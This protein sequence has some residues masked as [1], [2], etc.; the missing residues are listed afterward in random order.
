MARTGD[1]SSI[2]AR[3]GEHLR[4]AAED[5]V[6]L[7]AVG[8]WRDIEF[9][10]EALPELGPADV[11][12]S[13]EFLGHRLRAPLLI[14]GMTGGHDAA[15]GINAAL[16]SGAERRGVALGLGSQRAALLD[17]TL[18][19]TYSVVRSVAPTAFVLGNI[20][21]AQLLPQGAE[22]PLSNPQLRAAV[23]M[24]RADAL[25]IHLNFLEESVQVEGDRNA[26]GGLEAIARVVSAL[27][28]P[29]VAKETGAGISRPTSL[30]LAA[31]GVAALDVGG[32]G[33]TSF[34]AIEGRR[35][36]LLGQARG[37]RLGAMLRDWGI[38][39]PVSVV[40]ARKSGL[41]V[42]ATGGIRTGLDAAKA[43]ALGAT[44]A[45]VARPLLLAARDGEE[46][47]QAWIDG[48]LEELRT[49][50]FLLGARTT[51]DLR[52]ARLVIGGRTREWLEQLG[53]LDELQNYARE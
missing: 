8:P 44:L 38:P 32:R 17:P 7:A 46:G 52:R 36:E 45:G 37:S 13:V 4:L 24:V 47:V 33:G 31:A 15:R 29:V 2:E 27:D 34:A 23:A 28:V 51:G 1:A 19:P 11:D 10:H 5:D 6:D 3:K 43:I 49:V 18:A 26:A 25:A 9:E 14:A 12:L 35:A 30:R 16:A 20:G 48:F 42:I 53:L 50:M 39:T 21:V 40:A 41:P 22:P